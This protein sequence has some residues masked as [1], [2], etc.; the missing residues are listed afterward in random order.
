MESYQSIGLLMGID[1][2]N[3]RHIGEC[4]YRLTRS[5]GCRCFLYWYRSAIGQYK[6]S[7]KRRN[8]IDSS[9]Y[10]WEPSLNNT[11]CY[12]TTLQ[13]RIGIGD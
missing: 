2:V 8:S 1:W 7:Q 11:R 12:G 13:T 3:T 5:V 6:T 9:W 4:R 10:N